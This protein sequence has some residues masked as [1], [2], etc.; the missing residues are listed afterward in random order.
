[1]SVRVFV[2]DL[3]EFRAVVAAAR[4]MPSCTVREPRHGFWSLES[5]TQL[6]FERKP[7]KLGPALW[8]SLLGGGYC[9]RILE[10]GRD[11]LVIGPDAP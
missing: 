7:M 3:P 1:M 9:G 10:F 8:N 11:R 4:A 6:V 5:A 2:P